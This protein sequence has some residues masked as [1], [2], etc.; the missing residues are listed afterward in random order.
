MEIC[1]DESK[2]KE[3]IKQALVEVLEDRKGIIYELLSEIIED[4]AL[5]HAIREGEATGQVSKREILDSF[6]DQA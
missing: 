3:V 4:I 1:V 5:A 6:R 2:L